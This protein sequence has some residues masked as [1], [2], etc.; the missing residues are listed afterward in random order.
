MALLGVRFSEQQ[1]ILPEHAYVQHTYA[2]ARE[3]DGTLFLVCLLTD[4]QHEQRAAAAEKEY[5]RKREEAVHVIQLAWRNRAM[6]GYLR[7]RFEVPGKMVA[8]S[9]FHVAGIGPLAKLIQFR[10]E[11]LCTVRT[12]SACFAVI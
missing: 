9:A 10:E 2:R 12:G 11:G 4:P 1:L 6:R 3:A 8:I 5:L 7:A